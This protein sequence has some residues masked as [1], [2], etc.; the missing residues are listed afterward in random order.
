MDSGLGYF[1]EISENKAKSI[2]EAFANFAGNNVKGS[3]KKESGIFK[4]GEIVSV[5]GSLFRISNIS[6]HKLSLTL[7][8]DQEKTALQQKALAGV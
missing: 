6:R 3:L 2:E 1:T 5:K 8:S 4:I 7:V